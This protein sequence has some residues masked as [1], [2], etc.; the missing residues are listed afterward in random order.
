MR[1]LLLAIVSLA[2][3]AGCGPSSR[4]TPEQD[5]GTDP[6]G[7][8]AGGGGGAPTDDGDDGDDPVGPTADAAP[9]T[10]TTYVFAHSADTLYRVD[11]D[12]L[13]IEPVAAFG[14]PVGS[15]Q[16]TDIA[17]DRSGHM[18]GVSF[19]RVYAVDP[20]TAACTYLADLENSFNGLSYVPRPGAADQE[21]LLGAAQDGSV[22]ELDPATGATTPRGNYGDG[23]GSSGDIV[24]VDGF[25]T[26]ATVTDL[27]DDDDRLATVDP[28]DGDATVVG[29]TG[30][31][32]IW[33]LGYWGDQVYGFAEDGTF[34]LIDRTTGAAQVVDFSGISWWGAGVTTS[35]PVTID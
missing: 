1:V 8:D 6:A 19:D 30:I 32:D 20:D 28:M 26:A 12:T 23:M 31:V 16:M 11:P 17:L 5:D 27:W 18:I 2:M 33:G 4:D 9:T 35:A 21:M 29:A 14:W 13:Q 24:S 34:V 3:A 15:D 25:G 10:G 22:Y 7:A